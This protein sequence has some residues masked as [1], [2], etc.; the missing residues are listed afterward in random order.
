MPASSVGVSESLVLM[1][2]EATRFQSAVHHYPAAHAPV[3]GSGL[4]MHSWRW[5][6][7]RRVM[8]GKIQLRTAQP[9]RVATTRV[10]QS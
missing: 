5:M 7:L 6:T 8:G 10:L 1:R 9:T 2:S 3:P 4:L